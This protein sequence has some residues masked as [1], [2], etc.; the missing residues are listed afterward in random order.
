MNN[1]DIQNEYIDFL[2]KENENKFKTPR[3]S[4]KKRRSGIMVVEKE[5]LK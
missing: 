2:N 3:I 5:D 4:I 1:C